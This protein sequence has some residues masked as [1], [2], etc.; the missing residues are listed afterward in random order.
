[1][2]SAIE[3][4]NK[5]VVRWRE[6]LRIYLGKHCGNKRHTYARRNRRYRQFGIKGESHHAAATATVIVDTSGSISTEEIQQFFG[7]IESILY[8]TTVTLV[9]C[10]AVVHHCA[11]YKRGDWRKIEVKGRGG[12][13]MVAAFDY[14]E[15]NQA[16]GDVVILLTDGETPWPED[17]GYPSIF[18]ITRAPSG[19]K[20]GHS[21]FINKNNYETS[22]L[23]DDTI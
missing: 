8:R 9:Q 21:I 13:N 3:E 19:P 23:N 2:K 10:D 12:T 6:L 4:L 7:E 20:W 17:R 5:P 16:V 15:K 18:V 11:K 1:M 14:I 22:D